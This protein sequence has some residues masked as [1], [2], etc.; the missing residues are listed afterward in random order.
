[1]AARARFH[2][3]GGLHRSRRLMVKPA[4]HLSDEMLEDRVG[5]GGLLVSYPPVDR[6][7]AEVR[8]TADLRNAGAA[9]ARARVTHRLFDGEQ[10]VATSSAS[11]TLA[12]RSPGRTVQT[13]LVP[14]RL[15]VELDD[16]GVA[17]VD[18]DL[19][20]VRAT[21][22]N[23]DGRPVPT[24]RG[25]V[26]FAAGGDYQ[27]VGGTELELEAESRRRWFEP[28]QCRQSGRS[29]PRRSRWAPA[30]LRRAE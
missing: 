29:V 28:G 8:V 1:M 4:V 16:A 30:D 12:R 24:A 23:G 21:A 5:G 14:G 11:L 26:T 25:R 13:L 22:F 17:P 9:A 6:D 18:G 3:Y 19:L 10:L 2:I 15:T 7:L 27:L 20:F